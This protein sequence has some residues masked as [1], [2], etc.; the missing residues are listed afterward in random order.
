MKDRACSIELT[1][2]TSIHNPL[3]TIGLGDRGKQVTIGSL[4]TSNGTILISGPFLEIR[5]LRNVN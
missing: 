4:S 2:A 5:L 3:I 1:H